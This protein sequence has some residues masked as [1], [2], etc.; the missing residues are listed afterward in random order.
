MIQPP[1]SNEEY[2]DDMEHGLIDQAK[3][4]GRL[5]ELIRTLRHQRWPEGAAQNSVAREEYDIE[6]EQLIQAA[7][8][9]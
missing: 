2:I 3:Q 7:I 1:G 5:A 4:I 9:G 6:T 8:D